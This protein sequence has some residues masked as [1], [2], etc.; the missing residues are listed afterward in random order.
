[1][2][3]F[4]EPIKTKLKDFTFFSGDEGN[5]LKQYETNFFSQKTIPPYPGIWGMV[6]R[7]NTEERCNNHFTLLYCV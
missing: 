3:L 1:M 2:F 5:V 6:F 7:S 4:L